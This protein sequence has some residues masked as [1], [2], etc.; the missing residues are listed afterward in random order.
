MTAFATKACGR[1][2]GGGHYSRNAYGSTA[3]YQCG[4][5]GKVLTKEGRAAQ[6]TFRELI[7]VEPAKV[8]P[9]WLVWW[10]DITLGPGK[11]VR[12]ADVQVRPDGAVDFTSQSGNKAGIKGGT[13]RAVESMAQRD[14]AVQQALEQHGEK[15]R[16]A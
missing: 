2:G 13:I 15:A 10:G 9:G 12:V 6:K 3:C 1:C 4:G 5:S 8:Q 14:A 7:S 11:W 16:A